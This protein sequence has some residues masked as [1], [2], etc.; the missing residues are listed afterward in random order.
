MAFINNETPAWIIDWINKVFTTSQS[1]TLFLWV[2]KD[3]VPISTSEY[4]YDEVSQELTYVDAPLY[5]VAVN[6]VVWTWTVL[7]NYE[8]LITN[9]SLIWTVDWTN[10][11]F[12]TNEPL[13]Q[14]ESLIRDWVHTLDY[15]YT[16]WDNKITFVDAPEVNQPYINYVTYWTTDSAN[17]FSWNTTQSELIDRLYSDILLEKTDS[18]VY[19]LETAKSMLSE[20]Q[21]AI[22][23]WE[24]VETLRSWK[25]KKHRANNLSFL[26]KTKNF[27]IY[28]STTLT[29]DHNV[30]DSTISIIWKEFPDFWTVFINW[31]VIWYTSINS[32]WTIISWLSKTDFIAKK[33]DQVKIIFPIPVDYW[34]ELTITVYSQNKE[35]VLP[36]LD[37]REVWKNNYQKYFKEI[38]DTTQWW[39]FLVNWLSTDDTVNISYYRIAPDITENVNTIIPWKYAIQILPYL[40]AFQMLINTDESAKAYDVKESWIEA[41]TRMYRNFEEVNKFRHKIWNDLDY[42]LATWP[43]F[44][45]LARKNSWYGR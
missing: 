32:E 11:V 29:E 26:K 17:D 13:K 3:W 39:Y 4:S 38:I 37:E 35:Q 31:N 10:T 14:V 1:Y 41:L 2:Y 45:N 23:R 36:K 9:E 27:K 44:S 15:S 42:R 16:P 21:D 12:F 7:S 5:N 28:E 8:L 40:V 30:W 33:W 24:Y 20:I 19:R 6:W 22:C 43:W 25:R 18:T 34:R